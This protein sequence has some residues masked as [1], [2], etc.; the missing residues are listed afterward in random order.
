MFIGL[1]KYTTLSILLF[2]ASVC[3]AFDTSSYVTIDKFIDENP[4]SQKQLMTSFSDLVSS[5]AIP[6]GLR[7]E[8][9]VK[10]AAIYPGGIQKSNYWKDSVTSME[11][12]LDELGIRHETSRFF[13]V[14]RRGG[15]SDYR[16]NN[17]QMH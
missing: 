17:W 6:V 9:P 8:K 10:I 7:M 12:R 2:T 13:S 5:Y 3:S 1:I 15:I 14:N 4:P 16:L 11:M